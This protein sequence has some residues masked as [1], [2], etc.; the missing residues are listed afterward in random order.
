MVGR[1]FANGRYE[2][3]EQIGEG[4]AALVFRGHDHHLGRDVAIKV[5]RPELAGD[6]EF[7]ERFRREATAAAGLCHPSIA[8]VYDIGMDSTTSYM[9][10]E[11]APGGTLAARVRASGALPCAEA[12][13]IAG[14]AAGALHHA[15][16]SGIVHRDIKPHNILFGRDGSVKVVDFGIA[17]ALAQASI[18]QTGTIVGSVHYLSPEQARGE[19]ATPQSDL[20]ALGV[21]LFEM[22]TGKVPFEGDT[23][24]GVA[25]RHVQDVAPDVRALNPNVPNA[26]AAIVQRALAKSPEDR[27]RSANEMRA[28]LERARQAVA[29]GGTGGGATL[30]DQATRRIAKPTL[31]PPVHPSVRAARPPIHQPLEPEGLSGFTWALVVLTI[32]VVIAGIGV[33]WWVNNPGGTK[34]PG[35]GT[36]T[37][38][39]A[40]AS[41]TMPNVVGAEINRAKRELRN[42]G[43]DERFVRISEQSSDI[44]PEGT[45]IRQSPP[46]GAPWTEGDSVT[47]VVSSGQSEEDKLVPVPDCVGLEDKAAT[48]LLAEAKL[49]LKIEIRETTGD[50]TPNSVIDQSPSAGSQVAKGTEVRLW[51]ARPAKAKP[52]DDEPAKNPGGAEPKAPTGP[53]GGTGTGTP[54]GGKAPPAAPEP[55][56]PAVDNT[57][58]D[59]GPVDGAAGR[60]GPAGD[61]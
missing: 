23:P 17:R 33:V 28:D 42:E 56:P 19:P 60:P 61:L 13:R 48:K 53:G 15:H 49:K 50:E 59:G 2:I 51:V 24:V 54:G 35:S 34:T 40:Q 30:L 45:V 7:A 1:V 12:L 39:T 6:P 41:A 10:M 5:L 57:T 3:L 38:A 21:V 9:V 27:Y 36:G 18:S 43:I 26:V 16:E 11:L 29:T 46:A 4:G 8:Q 52:V 55:P 47:I 20:Y 31:P 44:A 25:L 22:L 58:D 37:G 14:E 32:V